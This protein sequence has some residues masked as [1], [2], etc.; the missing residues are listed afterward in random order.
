MRPG[1][2]F[3]CADL[4]GEITPHHVQAA[5]SIELIHNS[6]LLH[7]DVL[8]KSDVRRGRMTAHKKW[9]E[10][11]SI[12]TGDYLLCLARKSCTRRSWSVLRLI[13]ESATRVVAGQALE[14]A[15]PPLPIFE[16][17]DHY[18]NV[19]Q[20]KT[21]ALFEAAA[22]STKFAQTPLPRSMKLLL[23]LGITLVSFFSYQ[24]IS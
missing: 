14:M 3:S 10:R 7:D 8:D 6:T 9:S 13:Q 4:L 5:L 12:L 22:G 17:E 23:P 21:A 18:Q 1:L 11:H 20:N 16:Q 15:P 2:L 19:I 24:T